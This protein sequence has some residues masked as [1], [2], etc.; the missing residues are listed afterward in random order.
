MKFLILILT[1]CFLSSADD[2]YLKPDTTLGEYGTK[3]LEFKN[4]G[5][6]VADNSF[7]YIADEG[8]LRIQKIDLNGKYICETERNLSDL[9]TIF[10]LAVDVGNNVYVAG[11]EK[12]QIIQFCAD[13]LTFMQ[14]LEIYGGFLSYEKTG[15]LMIL[16]DRE[17]YITKYS[18]SSYY[19]EQITL[20]TN[21]ISNTPLDMVANKQK[22]WVLGKTK[23]ATCDNYGME[24]KTLDLPK[25]IKNG[26][27]SHVKNNMIIGV[28]D[29]NVY[30]ISEYNFKLFG[31]LNPDI[32]VGGIAYTNKDL[33]ISDRKNNCIKRFPLN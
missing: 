5:K 21:M 8:N 12:S 15:N 28:F 33:W 2:T 29:N 11:S 25:P 13:N 14:K 7:L 9:H 17:N 18:L 23:I 22:I 4:P 10:D 6:I 30:L 19:T 24:S 31:K 3:K 1:I 27:I 32:Q 20:P 16:S 26:F